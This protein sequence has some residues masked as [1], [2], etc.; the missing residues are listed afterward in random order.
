MSYIR[1]QVTGYDLNK[2]M[3]V[4]RF[5][6][7]PLVPRSLTRYLFL[8][9]CPNP[10]AFSSAF[11]LAAVVHETLR[12]F[13]LKIT[14]SAMA[15]FVVVC[16]CIGFIVR[17]SFPCKVF[18]SETIIG[19]SGFKHTGMPCTAVLSIVGHVEFFRTICAGCK[20]WPQPFDTVTL[21]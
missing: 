4:M 14:Y 12:V 8:N 13:V 6:H 2:S 3:S 15:I 1:I 21:N 5:L 18:S 20:L 9:V 19:R 11:T 16:P 7:H 10:T 17:L